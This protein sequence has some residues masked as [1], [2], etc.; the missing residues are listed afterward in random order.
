MTDDRA[1]ASE[2]EW[3][4]AFEGQRP[5]FELGNVPANAF[6]PGNMPANATH[7]AYSQRYVEPLAR[8][9]LEALLAD[10]AMPAHAKALAYRLELLALCRGE[11]QIQL[12]TEWLAKRAEKTEDGI[13][14]LDDEA[15]VRAY[16]LLHR[17]ETRAAS[18]RSRLGLTPVSAARLGKNVAQGQV[19]QADVAL[20]MARLHELEKQGWTPPAGWTGSDQSGEG[21]TDGGAD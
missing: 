20:A 21:G 12:I 14:N 1:L 16:L 17:A 7:K 3:E 15:T 6:E 4:P 5:P 19:A 8:D 2:A 9:L 13:G 10:D 18:A 11:A